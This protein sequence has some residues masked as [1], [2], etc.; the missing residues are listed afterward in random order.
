MFHRLKIPERN[1]VTIFEFLKLHPIQ[2]QKLD[3]SHLFTRDCVGRNVLRKWLSYDDANKK[4]YCST[5]M[6][7]SDH[8]NAF[9]TGVVL[10]KKHTSTRI[11]EHESSDTHLT[12]ADAFIRHDKNKTID[13]LFDNK[14]RILRLS[15]V[16]RNQEVVKRI[17]HWILCMG[18]QG[19]AY[20][21]SSES[22]KSFN[23]VSVNHGNLLEILLTASQHD[24]SV[25][26]H[27]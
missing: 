17:V 6:A 8:R 7:F 12:A 11:K 3:I 20:R 26:Q 10:D 23:D 4:F 22:A 27:H 9:R 14:Q 1:Q 2:P 19:F 13:E 16:Q 15:N 21:G 18:R 5:C 24:L 25:K